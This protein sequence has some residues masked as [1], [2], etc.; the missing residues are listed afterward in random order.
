V[1]AL[2]TATPTSQHRF[3][4]EFK[5]YSDAVVEQAEDRDIKSYFDLRRDNVAIRVTFAILEVHLNLPDRVFSDP[6]IYRLIK[7]CVDMVF[8]GNDVLSYNIK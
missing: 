4:S 8:I 7:G 5:L 3:I 1:N 6:I 2:R